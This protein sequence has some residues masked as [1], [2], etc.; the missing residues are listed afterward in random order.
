MYIESASDSCPLLLHCSTSIQEQSVIRVFR[1]FILHTVNYKRTHII[2]SQP[3]LV[4]LS[5]NFNLRAPGNHSF[6]V[7]QCNFT[8]CTV[9]FVVTQVGRV[10]SSSR[11]SGS[12]GFAI[13][14]NSGRGQSL[15]WKGR[16]ILDSP[17][18]IEAAR[19]HCFSLFLASSRRLLACELYNK[20]VVLLLF[21]FKL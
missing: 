12:A 19:R 16:C 1:D 15:R 11:S 3:A 9:I 21:S 5:Y 17:Y 2:N 14:R 8:L 13:I 7:L 20:M 10:A 18:A 6:E 4:P